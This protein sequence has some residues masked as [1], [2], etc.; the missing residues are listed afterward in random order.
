VEIS[1]LAAEQMKGY[2]AELGLTPTSRARLE[3][4]RKSNEPEE[5]DPMEA[6][7]SEIGR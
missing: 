3:L 6:L 7:L 4:S 1:K 2:A 5:E